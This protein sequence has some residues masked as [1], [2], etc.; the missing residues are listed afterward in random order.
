MYVINTWYNLSLFLH[1]PPLIAFYVFVP[2]W[3]TLCTFYSPFVL[4]L[5]LFG[6]F[7]IGHIHLFIFVVPL[8][9]LT[10]TPRPA[11]QLLLFSCD[12]CLLNGN[13]FV[14]SFID[15]VLNVVAILVPLRY[16]S[17]SL[18]DGWRFC[19]CCCCCCKW[20]ILFRYVVPLNTKL[21]SLFFFL[22][23]FYSIKIAFTPTIRQKKN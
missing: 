2:C 5:T 9:L 4:L 18:F 6:F 16:H 23:I 15:D 20:K 14:C 11:H 3:G 10:V 19:W 13:I 17:Y 21:F 7:I 1:S 8:T 22:F 12:F